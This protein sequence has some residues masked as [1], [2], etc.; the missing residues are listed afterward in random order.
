MLQNLFCIF[1]SS[2]L[3]QGYKTYMVFIEHS[4]EYIL[5]IEMYL[6]SDIMLKLKVP[7]LPHVPI[8]PRFP[9]QS[10]FAPT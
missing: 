6:C 8:L 5:S 7:I 9:Q 4:N 2:L 1:L 3:L 10:N